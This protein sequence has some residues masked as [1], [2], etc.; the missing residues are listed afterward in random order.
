VNSGQVGTAE[1]PSGHR[2]ESG[3]I[4]R[5][6]SLV[7]QLLAVGNAVVEIDAQGR[8][9]CPAH[10]SAAHKARAVPAEVIVP[11][12]APGIEIRSG[13][14]PVAEPNLAARDSSQAQ[15]VFALPLLVRRALDL[16][17]PSRVPMRLYASTSVCSSEVRMAGDRVLLQL[18]RSI[19]GPTTPRLAIRTAASV[20]SPGGEDDR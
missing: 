13:S 7:H 18:M 10:R 2:E 9:G 15:W 16:R 6:Q 1:V 14:R 20:D 5:E 3:L 19:Q 12:M 4:G 8:D 17:M 11:L